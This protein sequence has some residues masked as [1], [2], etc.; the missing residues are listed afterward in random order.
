MFA[1]TVFLTR[2]LTHL[3]T[4]SAHTLFD[5]MPCSLCACTQFGSQPHDCFRLHFCSHPMFCVCSH[6]FLT[7]PH[8]FAHTFC[9]QPQLFLLTMFAHNPLFF[10][11]HDLLTPMCFFAHK[12]CSRPCLFL[13][14]WLLTPSYGVAQQCLFLAH[15]CPLVLYPSTLGHHVLHIPKALAYFVLM[16]CMFAYPCGPIYG[17]KASIMVPIHKSCLPHNKKPHSVL[18][19]T[20][21]DTSL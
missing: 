1:H 16:S 8:L 7:P 13:L 9:S 15:M 21:V 18:L 4:R 19:A 5:D 14:A 2:L 11:S 12:F 20:L 6:G 17:P 10:C 3:L